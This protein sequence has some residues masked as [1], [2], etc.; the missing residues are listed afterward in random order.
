ME[1]PLHPGGNT[2]IGPPLQATMKRDGKLK[3]KIPKVV[4]DQIIDRDKQSLI[5]KVQSM[6][7]NIDD[8]RKWTKNKWNN[9]G[10]MNI[11]ALPNNY[12][13]F[14]FKNEEDQNTI[15][16][17]PWFIGTMG[18]FLEKWQL[19]FDPIKECIMQAP[20]W[21]TLPNLPFD[22]WYQK[23]FEGIGNSFGRFFMMKK[24]TK[25]HARMIAARICVMVDFGIKL[26]TSIS[27]EEEMGNVE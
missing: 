16:S 17:T 10:N 15:L 21:V 4:I 23:V 14:V 12:L 20:I 22:I 2:T 8:V 27:L 3:L 19:R 7:P 24:I 25:A 18:L 6:R 26:S 1:G 9:K 5:N 13:L 11:I